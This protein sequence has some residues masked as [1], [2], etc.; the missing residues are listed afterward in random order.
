M[1]LSDVIQTI[2]IPVRSVNWVRLFP[3]LGRDGRDCLVAVMGQQADNFMVVQIDP[4]TG[5]TTQTAA[6]LHDS[7]YPTAAVRSRAGTIYIG[8]AHAGHLFRYDPKTGVLE[9]LGAINPPDDIFPCRIDEA[10]DGALWIGCYGTA[11][12]TRYD[13]TTGVFT[14]CGRMDETD[15][16]C[17]PLAAPDGTVACEIRVTRPHIVVFDPRT[18]AHRPVGPVVSKEEGGMVSL[19]RAQDGALYF[20][21]SAGKFRLNRFEAIPVDTLPEPEPPPTMSDGSVAAFSDAAS[22]RYRTVAITSPKIGAVRELP[23][24]YE[25]AGS[26][27]FLVH[28]G[29][30]DA[31]YGS[32]V[33]PLHLFR[34]DPDTGELAD[35]GAC[36]TAAG[37]AYSM[38]NL[39][40][41]LYICSYPAARLSVYD[42]ARPY[43]FG[44]DPDSNPRDIGR[45]DEVSYRPRAMVT[46]PLGRVWTA[47]I[48]DYGLWGGPLSWYDPRTERFGTYRD[49]A[50]AASCWSL[51]WLREHDLLAV[52]TTIQGGTGTQPRVRQA[53]LFL[54][55][56]KGERKVWEGDPG[57]P[58][59]SINALA[60]GGDG[61]LFGTLSGGDAP[62]ELFV[63]D[64]GTRT[65]THRLALP[66]GRPLDLGLQV[67]PDGMIYG[68][69]ASCLYRLNPSDLTVTPLIQEKDAF[70]VA[71][72]MRGDTIYFGKVHELKAVRVG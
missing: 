45:M 62:P 61:R 24:S 34:Y 21:S 46:G 63:F 49:I 54:W 6:A 20:D 52:G 48:P 3:A 32:S 5:A 19:I 37:E 60:V 39:E 7:N 70:Q 58:T 55:D 65:F 69:T 42:P 43:R 44:T 64:P 33:L 28:H 12:L 26:A 30:D 16:Y 35:L 1:A 53:T 31:L 72:P 23:I 2:G 36:S 67:G 17:Y 11:G 51:A 15:M 14:R 50:G 40:G 18:G 25:A 9:D 59:A 41:R 4:D 66:E 27:L 56:Y 38:G 10:P 22:Q 29:P 47:S 68:F 8:A 13:P 57:R 71:G